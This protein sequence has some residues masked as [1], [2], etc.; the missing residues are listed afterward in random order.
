MAPVPAGQE[1]Y[2]LQVICM[3]NSRALFSSEH[4]H[5]HCPM[6]SV[7]QTIT[8]SPQARCLGLGEGALAAVPRLL[9]LVRPQEVELEVHL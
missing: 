1:L 9:H 3:K 5:P 4:A 7:T 8:P 6:A 2:H